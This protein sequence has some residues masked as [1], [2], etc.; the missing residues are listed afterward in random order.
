MTAHVTSIGTAADALGTPSV[1]FPDGL[2]PPILTVDE[3]GPDGLP[4]PDGIVDPSGSNSQYQ[5]DTR[6][7]NDRALEYW[8]GQRNLGEIDVGDYDSVELRN[9]QGGGV[10][11][12]PEES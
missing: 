6:V 7:A 12:R 11:Y 10:A 1:V 3:L 8:S 2:R 5:R 4:G 9:N